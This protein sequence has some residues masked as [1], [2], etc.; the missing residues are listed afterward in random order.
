ML[1]AV[2]RKTASPLN[3]FSHGGPGDGQLHASTLDDVSAV[4]QST[5]MHVWIASLNGT[6]RRNIHIRLRAFIAEDPTRR[7][8]QRQRLPR[9]STTPDGRQPLSSI[10]VPSL[11]GSNPRCPAD[12]YRHRHFGEAPDA[13]H[14]ENGDPGCDAVLRR[15]CILTPTV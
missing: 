10:D 9:V 5:A 12:V 4:T 8:V 2:P 6:L 15:S 11:N 3:A 1:V 14:S 13:S 7:P